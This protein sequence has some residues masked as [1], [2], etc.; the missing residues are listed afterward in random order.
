MPVI[1]GT[2]GHIDHGKTSLVL[3]LTGV[4]CDRLAEEKRRGITIELGFAFLDLP[5]GSRLGVVDVPGHEKFV[6]N[7]VAGAQG[8]DFVLL[9][10]AADEG[11]MPQT[12][13]H[14][15]ICTLLGVQKGLV[16]LTKADVV[17]EELLELAA[18]DVQE[19]LA[20]TFLEGAPVIPVSSR[21]GDGLEAVRAALAETASG[22]AETRRTDLLRLPV[23]RVFTMRGHGAVVT[24][25]LSGGEL[26]VG[27]EVEVSPRGLA[28]K[29]RGVQSHGETLER[30]EAGRR[31][32]LN[33]QGLKVED[34]R[35]GDVICRPGT[36]F[37]STVMDL[38]L[39]CLASSPRALRHRREIHFHLG[40][41]ETLARLYFLDR[42]KLEPGDTALVQVRFAEPVPAVRGDRVVLRGFSPLRTVA[43][44]RV[45]SPL[46][47]GERR[48]ADRLARL[49][50]LQNADEAETALIQLEAAGFEGLDLRRLV[51]LTG[52]GAKELARIMEEHSNRGRALRF[53]AEA[54][55]YAHMQILENLERRL[56]EFVQAHHAEQPSK[57]GPGRGELGQAAGAKA[58]AK[59][60]QAALTRLVRRGELEQTQ[61][62]YRI[63]GFEPSAVGDAAALREMILSEYKE[64]G[65]TPPA[66]KEVLAKAKVKP[67]QAADV[68]RLLVQ[69]GELAKIKEDLFFSRQAWE[70][71]KAK[72]QAYFAENEDMAPGDFRDLTKLSRKYT[73]PLL[74]HLD[75][76]RVTVRVGDKRIARKR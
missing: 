74:E 63:P 19:E 38:E 46:G 48:K 28:S 2:A 67:A 49:K 72:V 45:L 17:D 52:A 16:A 70:E 15:E 62:A 73:I 11:V 42:E 39:T 8:I 61:E 14:V 35:R 56:A 25:T 21:T 57:P 54:G 34:L 30:V 22:V 40:S 59:L 32:A 20:G 23:D 26:A 18:E 66:L 3:A 64:A 6:K 76:E 55:R 43:G 7:M 24:G 33:L 71:I 68:L 1:M 58:R 36:L 10:V 53:D 50:A 4:D 69:Q 60:V 47:A 29:A 51:V 27:D 9:T 44:G 31:V 12:R 37:P 5:D 65:W 75:K 13:E 41:R